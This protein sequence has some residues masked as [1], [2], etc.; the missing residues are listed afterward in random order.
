MDKYGFRFKTYLYIVSVL[1]IT[2]WGISYIWTDKLIGLG[3]P[4]F[5]S[6]AAQPV[7]RPDEKDTQKRP[8]QISPS[9]TVRTVHLF[10]CGI[11]RHQ[12]DRFAYPEFDDNRHHPD[13]FGR[14]RIC[15]LQ[16]K[17]KLDQCHRHCTGHRR[18]MSCGDEPGRTRTALR[19][20]HHPSA[21]SCNK[22]SGACFRD[23]E[24]VR[25]L[26]EPGDSHVPVPD[27]LCIS[28]SA[29]HIQGTGRFQS[30]LS[31]RGGMGTD[32]MSRPVMFKP[33]I[34]YPFLNIQHRF[35]IP[36]SSCQHLL[37]HI[38]F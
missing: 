11:L 3:I 10:S 32:N 5:Y 28:S 1:A 22:R 38:H 17:D 18:H 23:Q 20:G 35:F 36:Q 21:G 15:L 26:S 29:L 27:R 34:V 14:C 13:I 2:L 37:K 33:C 31:F 24:P 4:V 16:G 19:L 9:G 8:A 25:E 7:D 6:A 30:R 12:G